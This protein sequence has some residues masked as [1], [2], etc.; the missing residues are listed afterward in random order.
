MRHASV[1][2]ARIEDIEGF[3]PGTYSYIVVVVVYWAT[4]FVL[5]PYV[6]EATSVCLASMMLITRIPTQ[7][8]FEKAHECHIVPLGRSWWAI[9][10]EISH[11]SYN[12]SLIQSEKWIQG[13][14]CR[15]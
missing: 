8:P 11:F 12:D 2:A 13:G 1:G 9:R 6:M 3:E 4:A 7:N 10:S 14:F 15:W 5:Q